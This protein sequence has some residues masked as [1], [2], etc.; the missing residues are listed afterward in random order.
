MRL[1]YPSLIAVGLV[2]AAGLLV[3]ALPAAAVGQQQSPTDRLQV[4]NL[5]THGMSTGKPN[6]DGTKTTDYRQ[7]IDYITD[8]T[9][10]TYLPDIVT[11]Q[12][13]GTAGEPSCQQF[14]TDLQNSAGGLDY[15]CYETTLQGGAA[16]V[17]RTG[18][19]SYVGGTR[20]SIQLKEIDSNGNCYPSSWYALILRLTDDRN[21]NHF[22]NV[23]SV[24][25]PTANY[26][27]GTGNLADCAW[28]NM[29]IVSPAVTGLGSASMQIMAGDWNHTDAT[30]DANGNYSFWECAY[31]GVNVD[32]TSC[33][34]QNFGWK[35][36]MYRACI[37][38]SDVFTCTRTNYWT[39]NSKWPSPP[40]LANLERIDFLFVKTY[41]IYSQVTVDWDAAYAVAGSPAGEQSRYSDHRGQG[42]L[43][44]YY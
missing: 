31:K 42:A 26:D 17:Y 27:P 16:I 20:Q 18:R 44:R 30:T 34:G 39:R 3:P 12:E 35:D 43:L 11:L 33:G 5:N 8:P 1:R 32:L 14:V 24:H 2:V 4:W 21:A 13:A 19:L 29:K 36:A 25:L 9:R 38:Q 15:N 22:I 10:V 28:D 7:F 41:A 6:S 40:Q 37:S 23:A